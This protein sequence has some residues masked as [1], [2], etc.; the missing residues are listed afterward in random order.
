MPLV[1]QVLET[2]KA[3]AGACEQ[4]SGAL[5]NLTWGSEAR[6][7]KLVEN[8]AVPHLGMVLETHKIHEGACEMASGAFW[9]IA[10]VASLKAVVISAGVVPLLANVWKCHAGAK[11]NAHG[12]LNAL[13]YNDDGS[14]KY[15]Y[16]QAF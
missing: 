12:A 5:I 4:A 11:T 2:H 10:S 6:T 9:S 15:V 1:A 7:Q 14:K 3:S 13:G 8:G 16:N